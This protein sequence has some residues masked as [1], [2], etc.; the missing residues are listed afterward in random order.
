MGNFEGLA[1]YTIALTRTFIS[2]TNVTFFPFSYE[3]EI[4]DF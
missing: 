1:T 2:R 4:V 3:Y